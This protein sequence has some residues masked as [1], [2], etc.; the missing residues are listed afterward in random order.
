[1]RD[2]SRYCM[3]GKPV[4]VRDLTILLQ[5]P[6]LEDTRLASAAFDREFEEARWQAARP[7]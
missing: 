6:A 2:I 7:N 1:M 3:T 4:D 5:H